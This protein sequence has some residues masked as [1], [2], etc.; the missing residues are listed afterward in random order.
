MQKMRYIFRKEKK[1]KIEKSP[2]SR[3]CFALTPRNVTNTKR[4]NFAQFRQHQMQKFQL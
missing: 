1:K 4:K 3:A 2:N